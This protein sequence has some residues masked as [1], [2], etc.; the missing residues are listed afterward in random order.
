MSKDKKDKQQPTTNERKS[1]V[2][3]VTYGDKDLIDCL[4]N[5]IRNEMNMI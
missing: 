1:I 3:K 5:I 2:V 4:K